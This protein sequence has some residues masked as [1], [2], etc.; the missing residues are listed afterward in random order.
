MASSSLGESERVGFSERVV[1]EERDERELVLVSVLGV[2]VEGQ[3]WGW[4]PW[5]DLV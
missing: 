5:L 1:E 4:R 3:Y 2:G